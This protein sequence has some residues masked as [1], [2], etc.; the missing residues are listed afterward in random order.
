MKS[1]H[2]IIASFILLIGM[3]SCSTNYL[4]VT[5]ISPNG[6]CLREI[7]AHGDSAFLT[8]DW[9]K[10]PY[11][12]QMDSSW[13]IMPIDSQDAAEQFN[14][15]YNVKISKSFRSLNEISAGLQFE[16]D[17]RLIVAP[18]E[19]LRKHFRWFYTYYSFKT[20]Y[21]V[22]SAQ[23]PV[24]ID[25][26]L[27]K[28]EQ[29]FWFQGD[30]S[31]Y[32]GLNGME[33]K[34][35]MDAIERRFWEWYARNIYESDFEAIREFEKL[36]GNNQFISRIQTVK[37]TLFQALFHDFSLENNSIE[38]IHIYKE[39]DKQLNTGYFSDQYKNNRQQIDSLIV[40][41][42]R[43]I[44]NLTNLLFDKEIDY[45]LIMP[46]KLISTNAPVI[47]QD[48]LLWKVNALRFT[49]G[50]YELTAESRTTH[51]WAFVLTFLLLLLSVYCLIKVKRYFH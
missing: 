27:N 23:I 42:E 32:A 14:S 20:V 45:E 37:D 17:L 11:L 4:I 18:E 47:R 33:L 26:Y 41:K 3:F 39:L 29:K 19:S 43:Y 5:T 36:S 48:T 9:S 35:E 34:D 16:E 25:D 13:R 31:A 51:L 6:A 46:G 10:N 24:S 28:S 30:Y 38:T 7:Y 15:K 1:N 44:E 50:D 2:R 22:I 40:E 8:G 21:P 49:A 12:F